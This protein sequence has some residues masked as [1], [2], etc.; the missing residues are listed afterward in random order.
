MFELSAEDPIALFQEWF[1]AA[2]KTETN[3]PNA[4]SLATVSADGKPSVRMVL[5]KEF[6]ARGF[7]FY[8]NFNSRKGQEL[9]NNPHAAL[10]FHWKSLNKQVRVEGKV[11]RVSDAEA[12]AYFKTRPRE[13]QI[14]AWASPQSYVL[15]DWSGLQ[16]N[17][18]KFT[19][20]FKGKDVSRPDHWSGFRVV[21]ERIEFWQQRPSRLH[22]RLVFMREGNNWITQ[23][24]FP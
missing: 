11:E 19:K 4:M 23:R 18:E 8:T 15:L 17:V 16:Q 12:D 1:E 9:Q 13:A 24:I 14:G 22:E 7:V 2:L 21:P 3:D 5:L 6:N 10:C 20:Q